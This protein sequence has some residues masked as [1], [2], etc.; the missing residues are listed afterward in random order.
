MKRLM[1]TAFE[2]F[3]G[4]TINPSLEAARL[5]TG[6]EFPGA[7][8]NVLELPVERHSAVEIALEGLRELRPDVVIM[9]GVA[10][11]RFRITPERVAINVDDFRIPDNAGNQPAGEPIVDGGPVGYFSTLPVRAIVDRLLTANIPSSISNSAGT[12]L[13]NRL[14]Y[15][16]MHHIATEGLPA[17]SG[18]IHVPYQHE[19][20][21]GKYPDIPSMSRE[22]IVEGVRLA[23]EVA[24]EHAS[25]TDALSL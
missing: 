9:L 1:L 8:V 13:C 20:A 23:I 11:A 19:M 25:L 24:I 15:S 16:V 12:Y 14:F 7:V 17:A 21:L 6:V 2:P 18:F 3:A 5:M 4:E 22:T 10:I